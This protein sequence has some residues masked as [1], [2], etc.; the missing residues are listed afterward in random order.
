[1]NLKI[2]TLCALSLITTAAY[3]DLSNTQAKRAIGSSTPATLSNLQTLCTS[4]KDFKGDLT[5]FNYKS[6]G[7]KFQEAYGAEV[8]QACSRG[9]ASYLHSDVIP[10]ENAFKN[11]SSQAE[12]ERTARNFTKKLDNYD[13]KGGSTKLFHRTYLDAQRVIERSSGSSSPDSDIENQL[14]MDLAA[15]KF[16]LEQALAAG[17]PDNIVRP[18]EQKLMYLEELKTRLGH[19]DGSSDGSG[20][21]ADPLPEPNWDVL[22]HGAPDLPLSSPPKIKPT[23]A[24]KPTFPPRH[25]APA[26]P[27][28]RAKAMIDGS[29][30]VD[31]TLE[32]EQI[33]H[34]LS[35]RESAFPSAS[36]QELKDHTRNRKRDLAGPLDGGGAGPA[37]GGGGLDDLLG[38]LSNPSDA[39][40]AA[41]VAGHSAVN[42]DGITNAMGSIYQAPHT[43]REPARTFEYVLNKALSRLHIHRDSVTASQRREL[44]T[45]FDA[46][47]QAS[48]G[49]ASAHVGAGNDLSKHQERRMHDALE[50]AYNDDNTRSF[51]ACLHI[52]KEEVNIKSITPTD[53]TKLE[54]WF[55]D[56][57]G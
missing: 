17:S 20:P 35:L 8:S 40:A 7:K 12:K 9:A 31:H 39:G 55:E 11:A 48:R 24:P 47:V 23:I 52:A 49:A 28:N 3:A 46:L 29:L 36:W 42:I 37:N 45:V 57:I 44:R 33:M 2:K 50:E 19:N 26:I 6:V 5:S 22:G 27:M 25:A 54:K 18:L 38:A 16:Q 21:A 30:S 4:L 43:L 53:K 10:A 13:T 56:N 15:V 51:A 34:D 14:R 32:F 1:M 41:D